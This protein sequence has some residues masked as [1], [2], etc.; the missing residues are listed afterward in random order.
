MPV[1]FQYVITKATKQNGAIQT[2][3]SIEIQNLDPKASTFTKT[4]TA[5][6][7]IDCSYEGDL[8]AKAGV[9]YTV[10]REDNKTYNE[11]WNGYTTT[12]QTPVP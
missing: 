10:G 6:M 12:R 1:L 3:K 11:T 8:M 5:K 2:I 9:S 4:I 7:F